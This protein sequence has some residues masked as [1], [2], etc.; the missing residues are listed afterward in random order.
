MQNV[1][2]AVVAGYRIERDARVATGLRFVLGREFCAASA[3]AKVLDHR[4]PERWLRDRFLAAKSARDFSDSVNTIA[5]RVAALQKVQPF[6]PLV[7][8]TA[9]LAR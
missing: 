2:F 8:A 3:E 4:E 1:H 7:T 6:L 5:Q 9:A